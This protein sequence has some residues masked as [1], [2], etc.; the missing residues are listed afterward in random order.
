MIAHV[1]LHQWR[2]HSV[3]NP[4]QDSCCFGN[5]ERIL[6]TN[7]VEHVNHLLIAKGP[8]NCRGIPKTLTGVD[9]RILMHIIQKARKK[10]R[11]Y[12]RAVTMSSMRLRDG[13]F[14]APFPFRP[15]VFPEL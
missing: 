11:S 9:Q 2:D 7:L 15:L 4:Y 3:E 13:T 1:V 14:P 6:G 8:A 5:C 10:S 12:I